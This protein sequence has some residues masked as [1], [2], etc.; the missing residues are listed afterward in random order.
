VRVGGRGRKADTVAIG[1]RIPA[2]LDRKL[3]EM[4]Q[5]R[6]VTPGAII[7]DLIK[8]EIERVQAG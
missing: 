1:F 5:D 3:R 6:G 7:E 8:K 4:A 2:E